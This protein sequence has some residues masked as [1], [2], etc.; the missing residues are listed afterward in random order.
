MMM[1]NFKQRLF[2]EQ[3]KQAKKQTMWS[4]FRARRDQPKNICRLFNVI[5]LSYLGCLLPNTLKYAEKSM[6]LNGSLNKAF[7]V[8]DRYHLAWQTWQDLPFKEMPLQGNMRSS[9]IEHLSSILV[10]YPS[11]Y[12]YINQFLAGANCPARSSFTEVMGEYLIREYNSGW[13]STVKIMVGSLTQ[14]AAGHLCY[15][16]KISHAILSF[17]SRTNCFKLKWTR[18]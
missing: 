15:L 7:L 8:D 4:F 6:S 18:K 16:F 10:Q 12:F 13:K 5:Q 11:E 9:K 1:L 3:R 17:W 2:L 14:L